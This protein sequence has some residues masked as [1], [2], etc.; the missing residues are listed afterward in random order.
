MNK[1][2]SGDLVR[3]SDVNSEIIWLVTENKN[4][5]VIVH[6]KAKTKDIG[7]LGSVWDLSKFDE[8]ELYRFSGTVNLIC[9]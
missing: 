9:S 2:K 7:R 1:F 5:G 8:N 4:I 6:S 3:W